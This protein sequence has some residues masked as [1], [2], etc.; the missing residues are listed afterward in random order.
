M[1]AGVPTPQ[2][3]V[4][5]Q[6]PFWK[7]NEGK[8]DIVTLLGVAMDVFNYF[9]PHIPI[10][11]ATMVG[12]ALRALLNIFGNPQ[13]TSA[14]V[15]LL[16]L[17][18]GMLVGTP[19]SANPLGVPLNPPALGEDDFLLAPIGAIEFNPTTPN[20]Y[21]LA[22]SE[23]FAFAH[24]L[25]SDDKHVVVEPYG[26]VGLFGAA[27]IGQWVATNGGASWSVDYGIMVGLPKLDASV[28]E[29][30][31]SATWNTINRGDAKLFINIAFPADILP[32]LLCR[33]LNL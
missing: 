30:A 20:N 32:D 26:F 7:T 5:P 16:V 24:V 6:V 27:N 22:I 29:V 11:M 3:P 31:F 17:L 14:S 12:I 9:S 28:P 8:K 2:P 10:G 21:G 23:S 33:K 1:N 25:P 4:V 19:A 15:L 13:S 18:G